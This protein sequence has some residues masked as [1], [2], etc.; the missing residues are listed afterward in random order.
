[1]IDDWLFGYSMTTLHPFQ[2]SHKS[3]LP[4][5]SAPAQSLHSL[6]DTRVP[7]LFILLHYM[8]FTNIQLNNFIPTLAQFIERLEIKGT[9]ET[10]WIMM[11]VLLSF[12][13]IMSLVHGK[14]ANGNL[15]NHGFSNLMP[16]EI[17]GEGTQYFILTYP[18]PME[19]TVGDKTIPMFFTF[20]KNCLYYWK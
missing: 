6:P 16:L 19:I 20:G 14:L 5:W 3:I 10:E 8:L 15:V 4:L 18:L 11:G 2:M 17:T 12:V 9:Q 7:D 1:M 13:E